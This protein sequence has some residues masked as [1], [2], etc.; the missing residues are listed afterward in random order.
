MHNENDCLIQKTHS[1]S[2]YLYNL[3]IKEEK[4]FTY[5]IFIFFTKN[6]VVSY[7]SY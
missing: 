6:D 3:S 7:K 5:K 4:K 2:L 1:F